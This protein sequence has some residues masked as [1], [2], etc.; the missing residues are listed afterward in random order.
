MG[1]LAP[2]FTGGPDPRRGVLPDVKGLER[3]IA[4]A[5]TDPEAARKLLADLAAK[6]FEPHPGQVPVMNAHERFLTMC[7][8]RRFGK[9]LRFDQQPPT[10]SGFKQAGDVTVGD[11]LFTQSGK[12]TKVTARFEHF[13]KLMYR[14]TFSDGATIECCSEHLWEVKNKNGRRA[15]TLDTQTI[16]RTFIKKRSDGKREHRWKL[17]RGR[18]VE[19]PEKQLPLPPYVV[20]ALLGDGC[21]TGGPRLC[22]NEYEIAERFRAEGMDLSK[23]DIRKNAAG[24]TTISYGIRK[25]LPK[26]RELGL[27]GHGFATK[28][29][30]DAYM[31]G[32]INQRLD[33]LHGLM[34]LYYPARYSFRK[35]RMASEYQA[36]V[37]CTSVLA[38]A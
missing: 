23:P 2:P 10:P 36:S 29:I 3:F 22:A 21:L 33:L 38:E 13:D 8:G 5:D 24:G 9:F 27:A 4:L 19:Y 32:S 15:R 30:P 6:K 18:P 26:L 34:G 16:A 31:Q 28:F 12:P 7:A 25:A 11:E 37:R 35:S 14:L 1:N 20:G 17:V